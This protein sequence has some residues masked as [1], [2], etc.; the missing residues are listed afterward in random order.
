VVIYDR[1]CRPWQFS[2]IVKLLEYEGLYLI[3]FSCGK[4]GH[5]ESQC[6]KKVVTHVPK[7]TNT[8]SQLSEKEL[9]VSV[10]SPSPIDPSSNPL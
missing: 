3:C 2:I 1:W 7:P 8:P 10:V 9:V 4:Y 5:K 6:P